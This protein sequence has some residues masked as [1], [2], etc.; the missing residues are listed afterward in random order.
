M[1]DNEGLLHCLDAE[2]GEHIWGHDL[3]ARDFYSSPLVA[4]GKVYVG[5]CRGEFWV[6][7]ASREK[8]VL[9][10]TRLDDEILACTAADGL[11]FIPTHR[12]S[13]AYYG[14]SR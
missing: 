3:G 8:E 12:S 2:T 4:D 5:T 10:Q 13:S 9:S 1:A 11:L 14:I 7:R 6:L